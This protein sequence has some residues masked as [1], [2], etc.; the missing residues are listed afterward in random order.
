M[1]M[2]Q[3]GRY[4]VRR[5]SLL[6][7]HRAFRR[8]PARVTFRGIVWIVRIAFRIPTTVKLGDAR[9]SFEL[10]LLLAR[11]GIATAVYLFRE[12]YEPELRY[13]QNLLSENMIVV[14]GGA[15]IGL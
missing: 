14:D 3:W 1:R 8:T 4:W 13:L 15:S 5:S 9:A 12:E 11:G 7:R 2:D 10:P 6:W